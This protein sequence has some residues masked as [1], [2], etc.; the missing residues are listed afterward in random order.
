MYT[1]DLNE[2]RSCVSQFKHALA[3]WMWLCISVCVSMR[4]CV[5]VCVC[6]CLK[7]RDRERLVLLREPILNQFCSDT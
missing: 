5:C 4:V 7:E 2:E 1:L 3:E 6:L